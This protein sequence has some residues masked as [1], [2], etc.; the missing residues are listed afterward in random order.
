VPEF[1]FERGVWKY[2]KGED[3][4]SLPQN[5]VLCDIGKEKET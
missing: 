5:A 4:V 3:A 2:V 1:R